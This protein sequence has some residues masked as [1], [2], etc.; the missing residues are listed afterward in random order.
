MRSYDIYFYAKTSIIGL[1]IKAIVFDIESLHCFTVVTLL[2]LVDITKG[3]SDISYC[4]LNLTGRWR[5]L[6]CS[7]KFVRRRRSLY[8]CVSRIS[9]PVGQADTGTNIAGGADLASC[10]SAGRH[11]SMDGHVHCMT[12]RGGRR[13]RGSRNRANVVVVFHKAEQS[14]RD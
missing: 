2:W 5:F 7:F 1:W 13:C 14:N 9:R 4:A 11:G 6:R 10:Y 3:R 12:A 8:C